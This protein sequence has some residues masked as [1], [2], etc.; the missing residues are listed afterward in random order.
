MALISLTGNQIDDVVKSELLVRM[1]DYAYSYD[2]PDVEE[3]LNFYKVWS[4]YAES[5]DYRILREEHPEIQK[6]V[7]AGW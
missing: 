6:I 7:N 3:V 2:T 5:G 1:C 4:F